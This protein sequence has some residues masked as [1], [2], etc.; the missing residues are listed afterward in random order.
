MHG[1]DLVIFAIVAVLGVVAY[2]RDPALPAVGFRKGGALLLD[3]LPRLVGAVI[4]T[5]LLQVLIAPEWIQQ[6]LGREAGHRGIL[7][8]FVAGLLTP[9]GP[10]VSFP[11]MAVF[12][13]SGASLG[14]LVCY[15]TSWSLSG[16][17][18]ILAWELPLMGPRFLLARVL[19]TLAFP[20]VA[21][22]LVR[23]FYED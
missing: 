8:A 2:L 6:W 18:R 15:V 11:V 9:G 20:L 19:P 4:L 14:A 17:Q 22:Y 5:G 13:Q 23:L 10:M 3:I 1:Y 16:F 21:G 7:A 12:Y